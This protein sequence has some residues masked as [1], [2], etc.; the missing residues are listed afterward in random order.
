MLND[1][2]DA[3]ARADIA[4]KAEEAQPHSAVMASI[5][6]LPVRKPMM[7]R[8]RKRTRAQAFTNELQSATNSKRIL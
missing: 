5:D 2:H 7:T 1:S 4:E 3:E 6:A 8:S